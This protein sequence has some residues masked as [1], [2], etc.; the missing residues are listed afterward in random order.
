MDNYDWSIFCLVVNAIIWVATFVVFQY[1]TRYF[2]VG[3]GILL[4]YAIISVLSVDLYDT[5]YGHLQI[6]LYP[7]LYLYGMIILAGSPILTIKEY[8]LKGIVHPNN[9]IFVI[10]SSVIVVLSL[11]SLSG[12]I[13]LIKDNIVKILLDNTYGSELYNTQTSEFQSKTSSQFNFIAIIGGTCGKIAIVFFMYYLTLGK[14]NKYLLWG[15]GISSIFGPINSIANGS[16]TSMAIFIMNGAFLFI[17]LRHFMPPK[18]KKKVT[19]IL[20]IVSICLL[21]PFFA[22]TV[23]RNNG[24]SEKAVEMVETYLCQGFLFFNQSGLDAN[25]T[26]E[27]DCTAVVFKYIAGMNPAMYYSGRLSKYSH[28]KLDEFVFYTFVGDFTLDYGPVWAFII[29]LFTAILFKAMLRPKN[30][31]I[32]FQQYVLIY[33]L[34]CGCLGYFHL[35][36][37]R[38][39][40]NLEMIALLLAALFFKLVSDIDSR[41]K[42]DCIMIPSISIAMATYNG[43]RYIRKQLDSILQQTVPFR[44][45]IISDDASTD[46]T[47]GIIC[48]YVRNDKR[49]KLFR[50]SCNNGFKSNFE[51]AIKHC[52]CD[53]V[54]LADQ[55]D[56]WMPFH[57]EFLS[58]SIGS[59]DLIC[60]DCNLTDKYGSLTHRR[61]WHTCSFK[62]D[63][64]VNDSVFRF[65]MYYQNPFRGASMMAKRDFLFSVIPIPDSVKYHDVWFVINAC[66]HNSFIFINDAVTCY[67]M[68]SDNASGIHGSRSSCLKT[69]IGHFIKHKLNNNRDDIV[70][71]M[72][73]IYGDKLISN[74]LLLDEADRYYRDR[75][76]ST[77]LRNIFFEIKHY[78]T[79]YGGL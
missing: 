71:E 56:I 53:M 79:I 33:L 43:E 19:K 8:K 27:G 37:A 30:E 72:K 31:K 6:T 24:N 61:L 26:R 73:R 40:G 36:L 58:E 62:K 17:F 44:E 9:K 65:V 13:A 66:L 22:I 60:G 69:L 5:S 11:V 14:K 75:R 16:R 78:K 2:G 59:N 45:L 46:I 7:F 28:M 48:E 23:S 47:W 25:G 20:C 15:L 77:R 35:P 42:N 68:H 18:I 39:A 34:L 32:T 63:V 67:R 57:L 52:S 54:A 3:S 10:V 50:N 4:L 49:I 41:K 76:W 70:V 74:N 21:V 38:E 55:D 51:I 12:T 64:V 1:K 29:F